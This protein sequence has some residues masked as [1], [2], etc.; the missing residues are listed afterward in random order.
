[1]FLNIMT[2][3]PLRSKLFVAFI[4]LLSSIS[5]SL[6]Q[7]HA[8]ESVALAQGGTGELDLAA[9]KA[10][11]DSHSVCFVDVRSEYVYYKSHIKGA[12]SLSKSR[13]D[14]QFPDF[15]QKKSLDTFIVVYCSEASCGKARSVAK[16]LI[17]IGYKNVKVYSGGLIE[18]AHAGLPMEGELIATHGQIINRE[19][20][21][22]LWPGLA[23]HQH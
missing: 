10:L 3:K 18:W 1:M 2:A 20:Q 14:E 16:K 22:R 12:I 9:T 13:F 11:Y 15:R 7:L 4:I 23:F 6:S 8:A 21:E 17:K 5:P 19:R